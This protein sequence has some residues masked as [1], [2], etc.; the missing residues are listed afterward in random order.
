MQE[1]ETQ[2]RPSQLLRQ[3]IDW[4]EA[5]PPGTHVRYFPVLG[6]SDYSVYQTD[7]LAFILGDHSAVVRLRFKAGCFALANLQPM[8]PTA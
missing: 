5:N 1:Q 7:G 3:C 4:N 2:P 8:E 6:R